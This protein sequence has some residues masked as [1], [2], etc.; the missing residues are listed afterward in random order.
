MDRPPQH[1][2]G[3]KV[4]CWTVS[5]RGGFYQLRGA[6]PPITV[7]AMAVAQYEDGGSIY[8]F[9]CNRNWEVVQ[10]WDCG[11]VEEAMELAAEHVGT[12]ALDWESH[13]S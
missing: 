7:V 13:A 10:D 9:T 3:A 1:L 2:D 12:E 5:P 11:S 6:D 8:L 4:V